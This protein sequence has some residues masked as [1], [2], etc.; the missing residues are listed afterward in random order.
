MMQW[1]ARHERGTA[2]TVDW[3]TPFQS[4]G[5]YVVGRDLRGGGDDPFVVFQIHV[6]KDVGGADTRSA[7]AEQIAGILNAV[8]GIQP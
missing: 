6:A 2:R 4:A 8:P 1:S 3:S 5:W 7:V